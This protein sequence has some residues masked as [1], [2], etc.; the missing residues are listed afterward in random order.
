[1]SNFTV[2][3]LKTGPGLDDLK[4]ICGDRKIYIWG[5][6]RGGRLWRRVLAAQGLTPAAYL[7]RDEAVRARPLDGLPVLS[8][9]AALAR[10]GEKDFI[11]IS[12]MP[13]PGLEPD[14]A[15][16]PEELCRRAGLRDDLDF[17]SI[18]RFERFRH[19]YYYTL[20]V[21]GPCNL[22]CISCPQGNGFRPAAPLFLSAE[23]FALAL[24]KINREDPSARDL[25]LF[26]WGEPL[27]NPQLPEIMDE[28]SQRHFSLFISTNL[29]LKADFRALLKPRPAP[30][31]LFVSLSGYGPSYE[32][33]HT[34]GRWPR[35][36]A[37]LEKL[38]ALRDELNPG[39]EITINYHLYRST[40]PDD[41]KRVQ[42]LCARLNLSLRSYFAF[43]HP[44]DVPAEI[45][46][47]RRPAGPGH[48]AVEAE[49]ILDTR[50]ALARCQE[51]KNRPCHV[52]M[53]LNL[54]HT[55]AVK[56]CCAWQGHELNNLAPDF[57][58]L[59]LEDLLR[60]RA[61]SELCRYC[62]R[63][64]LHRYVAANRGS[65]VDAFDNHDDPWQTEEL[66]LIQAGNRQ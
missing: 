9:E 3:H 34:G 53:G 31:M 41:Y 22:R 59:P 26:N 52:I 39:Q 46:E 60:A 1:M 54:D 13:R 20:E 51:Q 45:A 37:N 29:N 17:L 42:D 5:A 14:S 50:L 27:L 16:E 43:L 21:S 24:D 19:P 55:L 15:G 30:L 7:D 28:A 12:P 6:G 33:T 2:D 63:L 4:Q 49:L 44:L 10:P 18:W 57:L 65:N 40:S 62:R 11:F 61:D 8:P 32:R 66:R 35:F 36:L 48:R 56:H 38:A 64:G 58:E 23:R 25:A 47:G